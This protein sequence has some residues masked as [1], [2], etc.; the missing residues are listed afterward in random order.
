MVKINPV[1]VASVLATNATFD[2]VKVNPANNVQEEDDMYE[3]IS[4]NEY[5]FKGIFQNIFNIHYDYYYNILI[6]HNYE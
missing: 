1:E 2:E 3:E 6:A 5:R 4:K